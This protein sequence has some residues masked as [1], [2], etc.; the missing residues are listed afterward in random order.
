[1][2]HVEIMACYESKMVD[3][4]KNCQIAYIAIKSANSDLIIKKISISTLSIIFN[5]L[6]MLFKLGEFCWITLIQAFRCK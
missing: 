4:T 5:R 2:Y 6:E 1:M 3:I